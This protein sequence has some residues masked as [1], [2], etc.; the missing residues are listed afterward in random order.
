MLPPIP[1]HI[2][3][4]LLDHPLTGPHLSPTY[5]A[6][7]TPFYLYGSSATTNEYHIDH[8][9][10]RSPNISLSA[11]L[12][13]LAL[14][15]SS[16]LDDAL[17]DANDHPLLLFLDSVREE[18]MQPFPAS[19]ATLAA[20]PAFFFRKGATFD[21]SVWRDPVAGADGDVL[22]SWEELGRDGDEEGLVG[23]GE[24]KLGR[25]VWVD[26]EA[27]NWDPYKRVDDVAAWREEFEQ[28]GGKGR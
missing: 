3:R 21:V 1:L 12:D 2:T 15:S 26:A 25:D 6:T 8:A 23:T 16:P 13:S 9:L 10:V 19:N 17:A 18:A 4:P 14:N 27:L 20:L 28:I 7:R 24:V 22:R 5:P 11:T